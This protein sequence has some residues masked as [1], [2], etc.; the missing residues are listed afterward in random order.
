MVPEVT[1]IV[2]FIGCSSDAATFCASRGITGKVV[3]ICDEVFEIDVGFG[4]N[5]YAKVNEIKVVAGW[6]EIPILEE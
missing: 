2:R 5:I 1:D 4:Y 3:A 6:K